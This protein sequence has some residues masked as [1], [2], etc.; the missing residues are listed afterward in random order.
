MTH[1][2]D[3]HFED[4]GTVVVVTPL[5]LDAVTFTENETAIEDWQMI[6]NGF[7]CDHRIANGLAEF[8]TDHGFSI[9]A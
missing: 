5:N 9:T 2:A 1:T 7:A 6:G 3:F 4:H 8:I